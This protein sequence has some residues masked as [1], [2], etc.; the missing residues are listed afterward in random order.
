MEAETHARIVGFQKSTALKETDESLGLRAL[1]DV[2]A[3]GKLVGT[4]MPMSMRT[5]IAHECLA[6][7]QRAARVAVRGRCA[8]ARTPSDAHCVRVAGIGVNATDRVKMGDDQRGTLVQRVVGEVDSDEE[9]EASA[10]L[11]DA[12]S[13]SAIPVTA[14]DNVT[15]DDIES[16]LDTDLDCLTVEDLAA[17]LE[18]VDKLDAELAREEELAAAASSSDA[19]ASSGAATPAAVWRS[20]LIAS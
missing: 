9:E 5:R 7:V 12:P 2:D 8:C 4:H 19:A 6:T 13:L 18:E 1:V 3:T 15:L 20:K 11:K 14:A 16:K 17:L 10:L